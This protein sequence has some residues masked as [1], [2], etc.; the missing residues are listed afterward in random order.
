MKTG[1]QNIYRTCRRIAGITQEQAADKINVS[2]RSLADYES[3]RT[4]PGCDVVCLMV[5]A[6]QT[7]EL[8][9]LHLK[10]NTEVGR[11]YLPDIYLDELPRAV[12]RLQK[13]SRDL[14]IVESE[15]ISIACDGVVDQH[16]TPIWEQAKR[17]LMELA[18]AALA[19]MFCRRER[20]AYNI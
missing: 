15:L 10:Q 3:G 14:Q 19:V 16:E 20:T 13:E 6:Y 1:C 8:A 4:I 7:P 5:E 11:K 17:E 9:Y 2:V 12:L 18:G